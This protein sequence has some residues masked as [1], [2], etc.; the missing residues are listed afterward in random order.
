[1]GKLYSFALYVL[2][3]MSVTKKQDIKEVKKVLFL[4]T[5]P[6]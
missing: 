2:V 6:I 1:M 3:G 4:I 5:G